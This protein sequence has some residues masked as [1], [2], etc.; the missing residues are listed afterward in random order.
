MYQFDGPRWPVGKGKVKVMEIT[1]GKVEWM[2]AVARKCHPRSKTIEVVDYYFAAG[3]DDINLE[4]NRKFDGY[5]NDHFNPESVA[6]ILGYKSV[7]FNKDY[8]IT[9]VA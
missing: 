3:D 2:N 8:S 6:E 4:Y 5:S 1:I 7:R 9:A